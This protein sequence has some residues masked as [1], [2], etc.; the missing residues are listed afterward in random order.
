MKNRENFGNIEKDIMN[1][2]FKGS[3]KGIIS[4]FFLCFIL[5]SAVFASPIEEKKAELNQVENSLKAAQ[6]RLEAL[7]KQE[8]DITAQIKN[9]DSQVNLVQSE[10]DNL[11]ARA[12]LK[13]VQIK[14]REEKIALLQEEIE[15]KVAKINVYQKKL[16]SQTDSLNKRL[17]H[18]YTVGEEEYLDILLGARSFSELV[19]RLTI[20]SY[21]IKSDKILIE[22]IK[23]TKSLLA[24][25]KAE[26]ENKK[27]L[28]FSEKVRL[29]GELNE[30][31][32][33]R[34]E[35]LAKR[36]LIKRTLA[37]KQ[38]SLSR[39]LKNKAEVARLEEELERTS[40][41]LTSLI[42]RLESQS[43]SS[44]RPSSFI[45]PVNGT[46]TSHF[47]WRM[48]PILKVEKFHAGIDIAAPYGAEIKASAG[49]KVIFAGWLGG[50]GNT[51]IIDHGAGYS[52]LYAHCSVIIVSEGEEVSQG[53][54]IARVGSTGYSTGPHLHFEVRFNGEPQDPL[55]Y[56]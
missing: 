29:Q 22:E 31:S 19:S 25:K 45:W 43:S 23:H 36:A 9:L 51:L 41:Y 46:V 35:R 26:L 52:T 33:I 48:H 21:I 30:L 17:V 28:V 44:Q 10:I 55:N 40:R 50:Y 2:G 39:V 6:Q 56:L 38:S 54:I 53:E 8:R 16:D 1:S 18:I 11:E 27:E 42:R 15:E 12:R 3:S 24:K 4:A 13:Q 14:Q 47:G 5:A 32:Q 37:D 20:Y 7:K 34:N 49:G